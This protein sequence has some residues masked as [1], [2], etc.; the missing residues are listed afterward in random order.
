MYL[1]HFDFTGQPFQLT[2]DPTFFFASIGHARAAAY[3]EYGLCRAEGFVVITDRKS[4][5]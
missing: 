3:L 1:E 5:V 2:P 4:V